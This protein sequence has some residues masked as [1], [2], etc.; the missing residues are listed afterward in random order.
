MKF[1]TTLIA[2]FCGSLGFSL[3]YGLRGKLLFP[4]AFGGLISWGTFSIFNMIFSPSQII[5]SCFL[6]TAVSAI[7]VHIIAYLS[8]APTILFLLPAVIPLVPGSDLYNTF[9]CLYRNDRFNAKLH[10]A[11]CLKFVFAV[12]AGMAVVWALKLFHRRL[13]VTESK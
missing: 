1:V 3:L 2:A 13:A 6:A 7:Y 5:L 8:K 9:L 11:N 12:A 10:A 4:A